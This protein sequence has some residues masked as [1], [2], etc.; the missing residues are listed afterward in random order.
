MAT[1]E[2][3]G[4]TGAAEASVDNP[5]AAE[6][7]ERTSALAPTNSVTLDWLTEVSQRFR[8][9]GNDK[10]RSFLSDNRLK[11]FAAVYYSFSTACSTTVPLK[12]SGFMSIHNLAGWVTTKPRKFSFVS[13]SRSTNS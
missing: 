9:R 8:L 6:L 2:P 10:P 5:P 7:I 3:S 12:K 11:F 1:G 4:E 13:A